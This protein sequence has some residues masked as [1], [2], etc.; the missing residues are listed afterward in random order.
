MR[1]IFYWVAIVVSCS[2]YA[3]KVEYKVELIDEQGAP[4][5][6]KGTVVFNKKEVAYVRNGRGLLLLPRNAQWIFDVKTHLQPDDDLM[7]QAIYKGWTINKEAGKVTVRLQKVRT[8]TLVIT[9]PDG[10]PC[11]NATIVFQCYNNNDT[12]Q[13]KD[14]ANGLVKFTLPYQVN[15]SSDK[16]CNFII[17]GLPANVT[18]DKNGIVRI[19]ASRPKSAGSNQLAADQRLTDET[20][21]ILFNDIS[22]KP[23]ANQK[24]VIGGQTV[25]TDAQ[26]LVSLKM[27]NDLD[28]QGYNIENQQVDDKSNIV[29]VFLRSVFKPATIESESATLEAQLEALIH[30]LGDRNNIMEQAI[31]RIKLRI[32]ADRSF[33]KEQRERLTRQ[34]HILK[35]ITDQND[36]AYKKA[37]QEI[38]N[39]L[40]QINT[41][42]PV[43]TTIEKELL[44]TTQKLRQAEQD[45][46]RIQQEQKLAEEKSR[47]QLQAALSVAGFLFFLVLV[48]LVVNKSINRQKRELAF[49]MEEIN[50]QNDKIR[51]Q[52]EL[53]LMQQEE[54]ARKNMRLEELNNEKNSLMDIVAHDLKS[55][56]SK[57]VNIAQLLPVVGELNEEQRNYVNIIRKSALEGT[58]FIEDLLNINAIE[59]GQLLAITPEK[60]SL[61]VFL[62]ELLRN[63]R[64][65]ADAKSIRLHFQNKADDAVISTD[66]EYL[67]RIMENLISNAIKF[68]PSGGNVYVKVKDADMHLHISVQD[69]G[70]GISQEDQKYMFK[71]FQRLSARPTGREGSTGLGLAIVKLLTERLGGQIVVNS[72]ESS[73]GAEFIVMLPKA[74]SFY[75]Q[76]NETEQPIGAYVN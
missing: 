68:S 33:T 74:P 42:S 20:R 13:I 62:P 35:N 12:L 75:L 25:T 46:V 6:Q 2:A 32:N 14:V 48:F 9:Y 24:F 15:L 36:E 65:Q 63:F 49:R 72:T 28:I 58:R 69:E 39:I 4:V 66:R 37:H 21:L 57:V 43:D 45:K 8:V 51:S 29:K 1:A 31:E 60:I 19:T 50:R 47:M 64:N 70:P 73:K 56:L 18:A 40:R 67:K 26:G 17:D 61:P 41:R 38:K 44:L 59:Q 11:T 54:I 30:M 53:L 5:N 7:Y 55:P 3:Q 10:Q 23:F 71:K 16:A 22:K 52:N 27:L 76:D 34:I